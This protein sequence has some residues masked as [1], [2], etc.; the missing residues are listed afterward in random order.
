MGTPRPQDVGELSWILHNPEPKCNLLFDNGTQERAVL[1]YQNSLHNTLG[2]EATV[3]NTSN[4]AH[5]CCQA[6][7]FPPGSA[8]PNSKCTEGR[9]HASGLLLAKPVPPVP[10]HQYR[11]AELLTL[12]GKR[13][14]IPST[15]HLLLPRPG[16][17]I[18][19]SNQGI[20]RSIFKRSWLNL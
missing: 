17:I 11:S 20:T 1:T 15:G 10:G 18:K 14:H 16:E 3:R 9:G 2:R 13:T 12:Q 7:T 8:P 5:S 4:A 19:R 6:G